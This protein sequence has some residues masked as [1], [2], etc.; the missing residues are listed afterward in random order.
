MLWAASNWIPDY[1][2][3]KQLWL[4]FLM[5]HTV[6]RQSSPGLI[7]Q[8]SSSEIELSWLLPH[9]LKVTTM[10]QESLSHMKTPKTET[11]WEALSLMQPCFFTENEILPRSL[12][13]IPF[14]SIGQNWV[15]CPSLYHTHL[16]KSVS[17][18]TRSVDRKQRVVIASL[19]LLKMLR[20][21]NDTVMHL[22]HGKCSIH[23]CP[24]LV[25]KRS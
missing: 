12:Q 1:N 4:I 11:R 3:L 24:S 23:I 17:L 9:D 8:L 22:A 21:L 18:V 13:K 19:Y 6:W 7:L 2:W 14:R 20:S 25:I 15:T 16:N 5:Y 10:L